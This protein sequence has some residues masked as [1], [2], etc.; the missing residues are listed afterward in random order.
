MSEIPKL[1]RIQFDGH[2]YVLKLAYDLLVTERDALLL[3]AEK[4]ASALRE[5]KHNCQ[6]KHEALEEW[7]SFRDGGK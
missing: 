3:Q 1:V 4:L 5:I 6:A 7:S 2:D